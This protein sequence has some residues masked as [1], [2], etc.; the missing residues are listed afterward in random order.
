[1]GLIR[2]LLLTASNSDWLAQQMRRRRFARRA[3]SRFLPGEDAD[4][5]LLAAQRFA[6][7]GMASVLT[8]LGEN[9]KNAAEAEEVTRDYLMLM[10]RIK[11]RGL[12][13]HISVKLTHLGLDLGRD[14]CAA[15]LR[16]LI[17]HAAQAGNFVWIDMESSQYTDLTLELFRDLRAEHQNV[18]VCLQAY[19]RRTPA[20]LEALLPLKPTIRLVKGAYNEPPEIAFPSK[21]EVD[22]HFLMLA[23]Q[24]LDSRGSQF[25]PPG[26][27]THDMRLVARIRDV[28]RNRLIPD[29]AFEIQMLYGIRAADQRRLAADGC[30]VRVLVSYGTAW[31]AWYMRRLAE[32]P[33]NVWFVARSLVG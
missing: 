15:Q 2:K 25:H 3:V 29:Q 17:G 27:G 26:F 8:E 18:G 7:Q 32:R 9:V 22:R 12:P 24:L 1:M 6:D 20:D 10:D 14:I 5:A 13:A 30:R 33:A 19:L 16:S 4:A 28:V 31:F 21:R 11:Q 23:E